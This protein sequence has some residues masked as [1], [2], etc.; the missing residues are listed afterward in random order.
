M[1]AVQTKGF[2]RL[3]HVRRC[4]AALGHTALLDDACVGWMGNKG[5]GSSVTPSSCKRRDGEAGGPLRLQVT[6]LEPRVG[7][8]SR[9]SLRAG[10]KRP[11][12]TLRV[13]QAVTSGSPRLPLPAAPGRPLPFAFR[14]LLR[15][16]LSTLFP[17]LLP[18]QAN[19]SS[20]FKTPTT[21]ASVLLLLPEA[22]LPRPW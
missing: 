11:V 14:F 1:F 3:S 21:T 18:T 6:F 12:V 5:F 13:A 9:L 10:S 16:V 22:S 2:Q 8:A 19:S 20:S 17:A 15:A 7:A 4:P